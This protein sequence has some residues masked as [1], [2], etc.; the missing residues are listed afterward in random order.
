MNE[1]TQEEAMKRLEEAARRY[2]RY[3]QGKPHNVTVTLNDE[4]WNAVAFA[5]EG[6]LIA[7]RAEDSSIAPPWIDDQWVD[8]IKAIRTAVHD[9]IKP[10]AEAS[11]QQGA[12]ELLA[13]IEKE[14]KNDG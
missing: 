7:N 4:Q 5:I 13:E 8:A 2:S 1:Y 6:M 10:L 9:T 11:I 14:L 12:D 3:P